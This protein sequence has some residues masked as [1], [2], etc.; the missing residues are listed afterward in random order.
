MIRRQQKRPA[1][2]EQHVADEIRSRIGVGEEI[3]GDYGEI[4]EPRFLDEFGDLMTAQLLPAGGDADAAI[5]RVGNGDLLAFAEFLEGMQG[6]GCPF[7]VLL[8][9][10]GDQVA[11]DHA[12]DD[13]DQV[14]FPHQIVGGHSHTRAFEMGFEK[15]G[16]GE[17]RFQCQLVFRAAIH[18]N[19]YRFQHDDLLHTS[20]DGRGADLRHRPVA[21]LR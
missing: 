11:F 12:A 17:R 6:L 14:S 15:P 18:G 21:S 8:V 13:I 19:E 20:A 10:M 16:G 3:A 2:A 1:A 5:R 7:A 9:E 4:V